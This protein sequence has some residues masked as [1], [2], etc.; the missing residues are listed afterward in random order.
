MSSLNESHIPVVNETW[1]FG[2]GEYSVK[3]LKN[4]IRYFPTCCILNE[5]S[6][7]VAWILTY[8]YCAMGMLYTQPDH[9]RKGYAKLLI[10]TMSKRLH[11]QG[12]PVFC[13]VEE[14][15]QLSYRLFKS[16]GFEE[17]PS[18]RAAWFH[19]NQLG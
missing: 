9:R 11:T 8:N 15:N 2:K 17:E 5:N 7:P 10:S 1:K 3:F 12:Y 18:Y 4:I 16:L 13:F 14:E 6:Q 19:F